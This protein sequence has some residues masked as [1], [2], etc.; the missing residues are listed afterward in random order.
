MWERQTKQYGN[1][2]FSIPSTI[3]LCLIL[4]SCIHKTAKLCVYIQVCVCVRCN[5]LYFTTD[6]IYQPQNCGWLSLPSRHWCKNTPHNLCRWGF[7][8]LCGG[9]VVDRGMQVK[10]C[11]FTKKFFPLECKETEPKTSRPPTE[12]Q[13][14]HLNPNTRGGILPPENHVY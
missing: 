3:I 8:R 11:L 13:I 10:N 12:R 5:L 6:Q 1:N 9:A 2:L 4:I 7:A 14:R